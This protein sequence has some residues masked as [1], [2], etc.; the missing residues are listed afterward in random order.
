MA[1]MLLPGSRACLL[2]ICTCRT[3]AA[4]PGLRSPGR[5]AAWP[6]MGQLV[7]CGLAARFLSRS[8][9]PGRAG[10]G[11][12]GGLG[13]EE[14]QGGRECEELGYHVERQGD[15][16]RGVSE[17]GPGPGRE[18]GRHQGERKKVALDSLSMGGNVSGESVMIS[19]RNG[20]RKTRRGTG[21]AGGIARVCS[22]HHDEVEGKL[23]DHRLWQAGRAM[24]AL[25]EGGRRARCGWR[26]RALRRRA[27]GGF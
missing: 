1:S 6:P 8:S 14:R 11:R 16:S 21:G 7:G 4:R 18:H 24:T 5:F 17:S 12:L 26:R 27:R 10:T 9:G 23:G 20:G 15:R 3:S 2:V 25:R 13:Q 19:I 22:G